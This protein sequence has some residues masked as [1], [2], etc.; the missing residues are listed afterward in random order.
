[1]EGPRIADLGG[2]ERRLVWAPAGGSE[3]GGL[4]I[5]GSSDA[6]DTWTDPVSIPDMANGYQPTI[7][8]GAMLWVSDAGNDQGRLVSSSDGGETW[9]ATEL[10]AAGPN[11]LV[12]TE[13]AAG[14][15]MVVLEGPTGDGKVWIR[16]LE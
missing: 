4:R 8:P 1:M 5:V 7:A 6:G 15:G 10:L 16:R 13:L 3:D 11:P 12:L 9:S 14:S 2:D